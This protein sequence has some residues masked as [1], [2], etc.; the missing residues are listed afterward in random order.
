MALDVKPE[1]DAAIYYYDHTLNIWLSKVPSLAIF[2]RLELLEQEHPGVR[3]LGPVKLLLPT[4][5]FDALEKSNLSLMKT[6]N[7]LEQPNSCALYFPPTFLMKQTAHAIGY[8][9]DQDYN[10]KTCCI[11]MSENPIEI[12]EEEGD[13]DEGESDGR[14]GISFSPS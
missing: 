11:D 3:Y 8:W 2:T 6:V 7:L 9:L 1:W 4:S 5:D 10:L 12:E 14:P 13:E